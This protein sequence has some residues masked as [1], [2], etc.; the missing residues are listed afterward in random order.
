M[1]LDSEVFQKLFYTPMIY[2]YIHIVH[3]GCIILIDALKFILYSAL[4]K[5]VSEV[6]WLEERHKMMLL[7]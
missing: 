7:G 1:A 3:T 6:I 5:N 4:K 2:S